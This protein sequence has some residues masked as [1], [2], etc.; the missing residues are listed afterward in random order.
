MMIVRRKEETHGVPD[1]PGMLGR[2]AAWQRGSSLFPGS[3]LQQ[4][5]LWLLQGGAGSRFRG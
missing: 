5:G 3:L 4:Q 2:G 1:P